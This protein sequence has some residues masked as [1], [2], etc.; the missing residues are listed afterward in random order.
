MGHPGNGFFRTGSPPSA[1]GFACA[2]V[3][4]VIPAAAAANASRLVI[5]T[6]YSC[7]GPKF[8]TIR[9]HELEYRPNVTQS[10]RR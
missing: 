6:S 7:R 2:L 4:M 10:R 8:S 1:A 5:N 3:T 9:Q